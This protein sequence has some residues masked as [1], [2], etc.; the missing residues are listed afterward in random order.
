MKNSPSAS[1]GFSQKYVDHRRAKYC[2]WF[3]YLGLEIEYK[4][5]FGSHRACRV[6]GIMGYKKVLIQTWSWLSRRLTVLRAYSVPVTFQVLFLFIT[7]CLRG[8]LQYFFTEEKEMK[9]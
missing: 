6:M 4:K 1:L 3:G 7:M 2:E 8:G 5:A 9:T